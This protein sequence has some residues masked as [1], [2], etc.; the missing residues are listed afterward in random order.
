MPGSADFRHQPFEVR[1]PMLVSFALQMKMI[2]TELVLD[3][4]LRLFRSMNGKLVRADL[5][6]MAFHEITSARRAQPEVK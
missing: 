2:M 6:M 1:V 4:R 3:D 5:D